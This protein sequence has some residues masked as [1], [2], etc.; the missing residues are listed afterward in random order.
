MIGC[1]PFVVWAIRE[2]D[3][4]SAR[5]FALRMTAQ[6]GVFSLAPSAKPRSDQLYSRGFRRGFAALKP[7]LWEVQ[8]RDQNHYGRSGSIHTSDTLCTGMLAPCIHVRS[9]HFWITGSIHRMADQRTTSEFFHR[10]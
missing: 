2:G 5:Q 9:D 3:P 1:G 4:M 10:S 6:Y 8:P 7:P